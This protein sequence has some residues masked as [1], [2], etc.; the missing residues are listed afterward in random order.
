MVRIRTMR[1]WGWTK[2][3]PSSSAANPTTTQGVDAGRPARWKALRQRSGR[4][5]FLCA[6][7]PATEEE[8]PRRPKRG[9]RPQSDGHLMRPQNAVRFSRAYLGVNR[10]SGEGTQ[11]SRRREGRHAHGA[12]EGDEDRGELHGEG[13]E[14]GLQHTHV[15]Q[16]LNQASFTHNP[17]LDRSREM[18]SPLAQGR[19][20]ASRAAREIA[21]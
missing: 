8:T 2:G 19:M 10:A 4:S 20:H 15:S 7:A 9:R 21:H 3:A 11:R 13:G 12:R 5:S 17:I 18:I 16:H 14:E 6:A 1:G